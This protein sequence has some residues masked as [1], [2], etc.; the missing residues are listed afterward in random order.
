MY[1]GFSGKKW[2]SSIFWRKKSHVTIF[3]LWIPI[4]S[5]TIFLKTLVSNIL[6][7][8]VHSSCG[9]L[10][11]HLFD[12]IEKKPCYWY[13]PKF[14]VFEYSI[15]IRFISNFV[16]CFQNTLETLL[17]KLIQKLQ[18]DVNTILALSPLKLI[19]RANDAPLTIFSEILLENFKNILFVD[20]KKIIK[21]FIWPKKIIILC[22]YVKMCLKNLP[23]KIWF[24][25]LLVII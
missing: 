24:S 23:K 14:I 9:W 16:K 3:K 10:W 1:K 12:K 8:M 11:F 18:H 13:W 22:Y 15:F 6:S 25:N 21:I 4:G 2:K 19:M 20:E 7:N 5:K 17:Y